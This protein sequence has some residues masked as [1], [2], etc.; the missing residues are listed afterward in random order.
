VSKRAIII[1]WQIVEDDREWRA[2]SQL[3]AP[4]T[5]SQ[6]GVPPWLGEMLG[7]LLLVGGVAIWR[8]HTPQIAA[9]QDNTP[10]QTQAPSPTMTER[11]RQAAPD[12]ALWGPERSLET[13]SVLF[14]FRQHDAA[15]IIAV[16]L[17]V[18]EIYA[19]IRRNF[20]LPSKSGAEKLVIDVS[21][22]QAPGQIYSRI[23]LLEGLDTLRVPS[24]ALYQAPVAFT[25]TELLA[26]SIALPMLDY[27]LIEARD[28][29]QISM[30]W[31][32]MMSSLELWQLWD[33]DLPLSRW[34][35]ALVKWVYVDLPTTKLGEAIP[36]PGHYTTLCT[37]HK[38]WLRSPQEIHLPFLCINP[39]QAQE[40]YPWWEAHHPPLRLGALAAP[41]NPEY[42]SG[43]LINRVVDGGQLIAL[44]TLVDYAVVT[45][46]RERLPL[47]LG[48]LGQ[49][50]TWETLIP[51]VY[52]VS[53]AEFEAGWQEYLSAHD[54]ALAKRVTQTAMPLPSP[55]SVQQSVHDLDRKEP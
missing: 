33:L 16:A 53:A 22:T 25:D 45:Y 15:S 13:P 47:L 14:T 36:L 49:F 7:L 52:G 31:Q 1:E 29:H 34:R 55:S 32:P 2:L 27:L 50:D 28:H 5:P 37:E 12:A 40:S 44:S 26:Q 38:L 54:D 21:V 42:Y 43:A 3:P 39:G 48:N 19:T 4:T 8:W 17:Q 18:E 24:P 11:G 35:N 30:K 46:G 20:G 23:L 6:R 9:H 51:A 41:F 10:R